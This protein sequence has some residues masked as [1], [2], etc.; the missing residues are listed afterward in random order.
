MLKIL[1]LSAILVAFAILALGVKILF[2]KD[3]EFI[4]YSC[5][6]ENEDFNDVDG[7][8]GCEIKEL[9]NCTENGKK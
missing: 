5:A 4:R 3:A 1:I 8:A 9:A 6:G 7:C 2:D